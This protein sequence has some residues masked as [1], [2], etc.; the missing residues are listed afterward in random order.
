MATAMA[1]GKRH[2]KPVV[3]EV[4]AGKMYEDGYAFFLSANGVWLTEVVPA[5][6]I[7]L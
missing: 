2:G 6:Y 5:A 7:R 4:L 3:L 1:V